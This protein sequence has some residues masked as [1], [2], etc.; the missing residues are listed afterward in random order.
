MRDRVFAVGDLR[1]RITGVGVEHQARRW[2]LVLEGRG[3]TPGADPGGERGERPPAPSE[4]DTGERQGV[5]AQR[6]PQRS[7]EK[8]ASDQCVGER[9]E[10]FSFPYAY[11]HA[12]AMEDTGKPSPPSQRSPNTGNPRASAGERA[13]ERPE[14]RSPAP[15]GAPNGHWEELI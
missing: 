1:L 5:E 6:S 3:G 7:P 8:T 13:G 2:Q 11:A 9:G 4:S 10:R 12:R 14:A 15:E